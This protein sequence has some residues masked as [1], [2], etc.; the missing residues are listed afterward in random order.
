M[1]WHAISA[2]P[3]HRGVGRRL[4]EDGVQLDARR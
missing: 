2:R 4:A 1:T 3:Y